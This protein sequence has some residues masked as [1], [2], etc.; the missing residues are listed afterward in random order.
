[1]R[2]NL[3]EKYLNAVM[4]KNLSSESNP[5]LRMI[6][7]FVKNVAMSLAFRKYGD[8]LIS[9]TLSNLGAVKVP[10]VMEAYIEHFDFML[11][12]FL[13]SFPNATVVSYQ[14]ALRFTWTSGMV[15]KDVERLFFTTLVRMGLPVR[16][17]SN[18]R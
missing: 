8:S 18:L 2:M 13:T 9:S 14:N 1:M 4:C 15:E 11:G 17:E 16:V 12:R 7:L 10:K 3:K 5:V 6:P